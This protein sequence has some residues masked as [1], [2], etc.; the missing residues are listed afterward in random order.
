MSLIQSAQ[1][2][3]CV[4]HKV[5]VQVP[6]LIAQASFCPLQLQLAAHISL[7]VAFVQKDPNNVTAEWHCKNM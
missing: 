7:K 2:V 3:P 5:S 6:H 4:L 1:R